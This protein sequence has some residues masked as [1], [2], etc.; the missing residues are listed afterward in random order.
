MSDGMDASWDGLGLIDWI[1]VWTMEPIT[2]FSP[3]WS[4]SQTSSQGDAHLRFGEAGPGYQC[5]HSSIGRA[6]CYP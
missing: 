2:T 6:A 5:T 1:M 3:P 4:F